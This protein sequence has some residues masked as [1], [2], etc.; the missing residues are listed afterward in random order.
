MVDSGHNKNRF[1][2]I[3]SDIAVVKHLI[4]NKK[5]VI[6]LADLFLSLFTPR[7]CLVWPIFRF[8]CIW[9]TGCLW[10]KSKNL[11]P[12]IYL[13][14]QN[15]KMIFASSSSFLMFCIPKFGLETQ[16]FLFCFKMESNLGEETVGRYQRRGVGRRRKNNMR[17]ETEV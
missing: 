13:R 7:F 11:N 14:C 8:M 17:G 3:N 5:W 4:L 2:K 15:R 12:L 1:R 10:P 16:M 9:C 6:I